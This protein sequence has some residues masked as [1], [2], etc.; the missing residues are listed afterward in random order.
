M[1]KPYIKI[2]KV[3]SSVALTTFQVL[4]S[5]T[6]LPYRTAQVSDVF[7]IATSFM[8]QHSWRG[9]LSIFFLSMYTPERKSASSS[10]PSSHQVMYAQRHPLPPFAEPSRAWVQLTGTPYHTPHAFFFSTC[11]IQ[12]QDH[13]LC[14]PL[15]I[16]SFSDTH[17][18]PT[19]LVFLNSLDCEFPWD[20]GVTLRLLKIHICCKYGILDGVNNRSCM[21]V[22][23]V[24]K[25]GEMLL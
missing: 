13:V 19:P 7:I 2:L 22:Q 23:I 10:V 15:I 12:P 6:R 25:H 3:T 16:S 1:N 24:F 8:G 20:P 18:D 4:S 5:Y 11:G 14:Q 21:Q 9:W 17:K